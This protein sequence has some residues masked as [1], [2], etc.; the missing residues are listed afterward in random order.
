[1]LAL[2]LRISLNYKQNENKIEAALKQTNSKLK[3][4]TIVI[5]SL[6]FGIFLPTSTGFSQS[7]LR[8]Y[9]DIGGSGGTTTPQ[10]DDSDNTAIYIVGGLVVAG[11]IAYMVITKMNKK[12]E[13]EADTSS[14]LSNFNA[15]DFASE[16]NEFEHEVAKAKDN[17]PVDV[18]IGIRNNKAFVSDKT[19]LMGVSVRF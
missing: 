2:L 19:Y 8:I 18:M 10:T 1:V 13:E 9:D 12:D 11:V 15:T 14:A 16:F 3:I 4:L 6:S 5:I 17:F 7:F